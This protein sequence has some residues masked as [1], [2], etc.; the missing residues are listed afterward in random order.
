MGHL[1]EALKRPFGNFTKLI[2]GIVLNLLPIV[3][4]LA[5]GYELRCA[6]T[7]MKNKIQL[8]KWEKF[9]DLFVT[10][11]LSFIIQFIYYLPG[12]I[13]IGLS[14]A[15]SAF[16]MIKYFAQSGMMDPQYLFNEANIGLLV[17]G[18]I[19]LFLGG[20]N[21]LSGLVRYSQNYKFGDGFGGEVWR[22]A[23]KWKFFGTIVA[24]L[25]YGAILTAILGYI[26]VVGNA[27]SGFIFGITIMTAIGLIYKKL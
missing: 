2:I 13:L 5:Y 7:A 20:W 3:N 18:I 24:M 10:G 15:G 4:F 21:G 1:T 17:A 22:K 14:L 8:P 12:L 11:L 9:G 27:I 25:I 19:L 6:N 16:E 23:F 26:P